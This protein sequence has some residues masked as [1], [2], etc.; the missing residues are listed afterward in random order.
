MIKSLRVEN[1]R[2]FKE[3]SVSDLQR[4]NVVAGKNATDGRATSDGRRSRNSRAGHGDCRFG[5]PNSCILESI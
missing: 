3:V 1:F 5:S 2:C 4:V